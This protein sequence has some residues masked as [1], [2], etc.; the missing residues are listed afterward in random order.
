[1]NFTYQRFIEV[2]ASTHSSIFLKVAFK[3]ISPSSLIRLRTLESQTGIFVSIVASNFDAK[4]ISF[5]LQIKFKKLL[6][7]LP[8]STSMKIFDKIFINSINLEKLTRKKLFKKLIKFPK[9]NEQKT[10]QIENLFEF[11]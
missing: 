10:F 4:E 7:G 1:M 11:N 8:K 9:F 6:F 2:Y 3:I 5:F